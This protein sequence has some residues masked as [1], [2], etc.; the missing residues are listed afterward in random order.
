MSQVYFHA[1]AWFHLDFAH[2]PS[3]SG[4]K[5]SARTSWISD[6]NATRDKA[7]SQFLLWRHEQNLTQRKAAEKLGLCRASIIN[8]DIG[9]YRPK[10]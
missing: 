3:S 10:A 2:D 6:M 7:K 9:K 1:Y 5:Y 8:L 4:P